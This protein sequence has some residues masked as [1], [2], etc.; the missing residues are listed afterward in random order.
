[1]EYTMRNRTFVLLVILGC[2]GANIVAHAQQEVYT[3]WVTR[4]GNG[5]QPFFFGYGRTLDFA[6]KLAFRACG[7]DCTIL[8]SGPGC[9]SI[10]MQKEE[11]FPR[12][13]VAGLGPETTTEDAN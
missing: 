1:M 8:K 3:V 4:N 10:V 13:C 7:D 5:P 9:V 6:E 11:F 2:L 12:G